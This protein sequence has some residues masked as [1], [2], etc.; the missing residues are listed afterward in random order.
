MA[1]YLNAEDLARLGPGAVVVDSD[2][3]IAQA[4]PAPEVCDG[5]RWGK[6]GDND[7]LTDAEQ[8]REG[9]FVLLRHGQRAEDPPGP[10]VTPD[11]YPD[12]TFGL[13]S[14][15]TDGTMLSVR[16][17]G[18][19]TERP[20]AMC[21]SP[22]W[23]RHVAAVLNATDVEAHPMVVAALRQVTDLQA[24][25]ERRRKA[26]DRHV[27]ATRQAVAGILG[28]LGLGPLTSFGVGTT[29]ALVAIK[30]RCEGLWRNDHRM[31]GAVLSAAASLWP[32]AP[33]AALDD[34]PAVVER[35]TAEV[36]RLRAAVPGVPAGAR[37][38]GGTDE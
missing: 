4:V 14:F 18:D 21:I 33:A 20:V 31:T 26:E 32:D 8:A 36:R 17:T 10:R 1:R 23:A 28:V 19:D 38:G 27:E 2:G 24:E 7:L 22:E 34:L 29:P 35:L 15:S 9:H 13:D 5:M 37:H 6:P 11:G 25:Y 16:M 3:E 30:Q 12:I